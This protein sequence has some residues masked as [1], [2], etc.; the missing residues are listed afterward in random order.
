MVYDEAEA[1]LELRHLLLELA[2]ALVEVGLGGVQAVVGADGEGGVGLVELAVDGRR[3]GGGGCS[4]L[5]AC[6]IH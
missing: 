4:V 2:V 1:L 3:G 6:F 5:R